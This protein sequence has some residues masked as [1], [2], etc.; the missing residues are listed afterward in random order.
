MNDLWPCFQ[1]GT[2]AQPHFLCRRSSVYREQDGSSLPRGLQ[3]FVPVLLAGLYR[4]PPGFLQ[5][6]SR[7]QSLKGNVHSLSTL[8]A[9]LATVTR[10]CLVCLLEPYS[11]CCLQQ[12]P[13]PTFVVAASGIQTVHG[14]S[15]CLPSL[16]AF[17]VIVS[18]LPNPMLCKLLLE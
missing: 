8:S 3:R 11:V 4:T 9:T 15:W 5:H 10:K 12:P 2:E 14:L 7:A 1:R 13:Q 18:A 17:L 16:L 6:D